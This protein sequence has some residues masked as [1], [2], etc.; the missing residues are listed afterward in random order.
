MGPVS[1]LLLSRLANLWKAVG[2]VLLL[3]QLRNLKYDLK[4]IL[5]LKFDMKSN[6][7]L[8]LAKLSFGIRTVVLYAR[9]SNLESFEFDQPY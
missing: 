8:I 3:D 9:I 6:L 4:K 2:L 7:N 1:L 5:F